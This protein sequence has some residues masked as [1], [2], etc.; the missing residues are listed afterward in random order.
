MGPNQ[1]ILVYVIPSK[2]MGL[3]LCSTNSLFENITPPYVLITLLGRHMSMTHYHA[4]LVSHHISREL[5]Y[6]LSM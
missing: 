4:R 6:T 1:D 3:L 5:V 2:E